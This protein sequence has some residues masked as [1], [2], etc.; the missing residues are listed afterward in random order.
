MG[1]YER[2]VPI[3]KATDGKCKKVLIYGEDPLI[4][5]KDPLIYGKDPLLF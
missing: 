2:Q 1:P 3:G 5:G 4:Y